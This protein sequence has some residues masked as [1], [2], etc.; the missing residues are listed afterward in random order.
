MPSPANIS[1]MIKVFIDTD[2]IID[3]LADRKPFSESAA[4]LF[5]RIEKK[6]IE[7][8]TSSQSISNLYCIL[9]RFDSHRNVIQVLG[10]L[11]S[12]IGILPVSQ[13][14][15]RKALQSGFTDFEDGIQNFCAE[16]ER[17][18]VI[19]TRNIRD[20]NKASIAVLSPDL[21]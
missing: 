2:V 15:I 4:I 11:L 20:Y 19:V 21:I 17:M 3:F 7:G 12:L 10:D 9:R 14:V 1:P 18:D 5:D 13:E 6:E 8:F 16:T